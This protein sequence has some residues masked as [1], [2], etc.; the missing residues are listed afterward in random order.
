VANQFD[1]IRNIKREEKKNG[2]QEILLTAKKAAM[3][4]VTQ[5]ETSGC[6][7]PLNLM[8]KITSKLSNCT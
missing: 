8:S 1:N 4:P 3:V 6:Y 7:C 5:G 2:R